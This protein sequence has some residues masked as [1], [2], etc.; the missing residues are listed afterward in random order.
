MV[1]KPKYQKFKK[2]SAFKQIRIAE[3]DLYAAEVLFTAPK[4]RPELILYQVQQAIEKSLKAVLVFEEK[5]VPLTH[6]LEL[7]ISELA[8]ADQ[9][10]FPEAINELTLFATV[11]RYTEGDEII[12]KKDVEAAIQLGKVVYHWAMGKLRQ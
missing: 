4:C 10:R 3:N 1:N 8:E 12:E 7:L 11:K 6:S 5:A 2:E 9:K